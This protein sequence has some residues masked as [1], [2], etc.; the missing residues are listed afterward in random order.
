MEFICILSDLNTEQAGLD[1]NSRKG[2]KKVAKLNMS[3]L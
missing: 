3:A 2:L 1:L